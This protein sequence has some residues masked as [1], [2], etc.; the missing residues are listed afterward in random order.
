M[1]IYVGSERSHERVE[2]QKE[3]FKDLNKGCVRADIWHDIRGIH[4][5]DLNIRR[6]RQNFDTRRNQIRNHNTQG[7]RQNF[8]CKISD[9]RQNF[10][11]SFLSIVKSTIFDKIS[12]AV[13]C[14]V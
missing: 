11:I 9:F 12:T 2:G 14:E 13:I 3:E 7:F 10:D 6:F 1:R 4:I 8:P 5:R